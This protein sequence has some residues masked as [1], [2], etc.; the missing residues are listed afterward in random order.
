MFYNFRI[1]VHN[2]TS[3]NIFNIPYMF[4]YNI[5]VSWYSDY[6]IYSYLE[7]KNWLNFDILTLNYIRFYYTWLYID[8]CYYLYQLIIYVFKL[9][10]NFLRS[11]Y[12]SRIILRNNLIYFLTNDFNQWDL[13]TYY[14]FSIFIHYFDY[15]N[16]LYVSVH[17]FFYVFHY[18]LNNWWL[19]VNRNVP[20]I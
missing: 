16:F 12:D 10:Y 11:I 20:F 1:I 14:L 19:D 2:M 9:W 3:K 5:V 17:F 18:L 13:R 7:T 6:T 8:K 15:I 4:N